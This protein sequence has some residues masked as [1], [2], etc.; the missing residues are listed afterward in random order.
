MAALKTDG[1]SPVIK[2]NIHKKASTIQNFVF[3]YRSCLSINENKKSNTAYKT[4][5]CMPE[6]DKMCKVP[7]CEKLCMTSLSI[8]SS[9]PTNKAEQMEKASCDNPLFLKIETKLALI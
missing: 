5:V 8:S 6:T 4:P 7:E 9:Y 3:L 1:E 2:T